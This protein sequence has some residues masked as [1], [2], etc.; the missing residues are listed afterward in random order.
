MIIIKYCKTGGAEFLGHMD[1][2]RHIHKTIKRAKIDVKLTSGFH[3]RMSINLSSPLPVGLKSESEYCV[4][5]AS[6]NGE[7]FKSLFNEYSPRGIKCV[8]AKTVE[9]K[10][11]VAAVVD[12]AEYRVTCPKINV[13]KILACKELPFTDKRGKTFNA[14]ERIFDLRY[15]KDSLVCRLAFG[16][17]NFKVY[18]FMELI[19]VA[20]YDVVKVA[21]L[22]KG[23][24]LDDVIDN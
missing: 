4:I 14:R 21:S 9:K 24:N 3:Q 22:V 11:N 5:D 6:Y 19:G 13:E 23:E 17:V 1:L 7:D 16:N 8:Y 18:D 12:G 15:E 10:I 2:L 20:D